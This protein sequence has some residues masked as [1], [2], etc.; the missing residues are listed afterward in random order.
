MVHNLRDFS[1]FSE[2]TAGGVVKEFDR[3]I[4]DAVTVPE[5]SASWHFSLIVCLTSAAFV[6]PQEG[7]MQ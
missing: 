4:L 3:A 2:K 7:R 1:S 5:V 6:R